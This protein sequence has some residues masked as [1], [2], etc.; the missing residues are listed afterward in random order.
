MGK[1]NSSNFGPF[2]FYRSATSLLFYASTNGTSWDAA[3]GLSLGTVAANVWYHVAAYRVGTTLYLF[4]D[5]VLTYSG[6]MSS[7]L[8][9]NANPIT[10]GGGYNGNEAVSGWI[11][12]VRITNGVGRKSAAFIVPTFQYPDTPSSSFDLY[13]SY[14][15]FGSK[16]DGINSAT[17]LTDVRGNTHSFIGNAQL[18]TA[19]AKFGSASLSF[20]GTGDCV[21]LNN[22]NDFNF[23]QGFTIEFWARVPSWSAYGGF[24]SK[25]INNATYSPFSVYLDVTTGRVG[26]LASVNG[27]SWGVNIF[28]TATLTINQWHHVACVRNGNTFQIFVNGVA[29]T[30]AT[31]AGALMVNTTQVSIGSNAADASV[32]LNGYMD[33]IRITNGA[34]RYTSSF[35]PPTQSFPIPLEYDTYKRSVGLLIHADGVNAS[36][37]VG[38]ITGKVMTAA[39]NAQISTVQ[40]KFGGASLLFDGT[41]DW[42]STPAHADLN[43]TSGDFTI[44]LW[45]YKT[46]AAQAFVLNKDGQSGAYYPQWWV[47]IGASNVLTAALGTGT[48]SPTVTTI[49]SAA[50]INLNQWYHIAFTRSGTTLRLFID[51]A[52]S[53]SATQ[54]VTMTD[55]GR[56][57]YIGYEP[58]TTPLYYTGY[59]DDIRITKGVARYTSTFTPPTRTFSD[60]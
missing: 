4:R 47:S 28:S 49:N 19:Q 57:L 30:S 23:D 27:S 20:D 26:F 21:L 22:S 36:T 45:I 6:T 15:V 31:L 55:G 48:S 54:A 50:P 18:S 53:N 40:S 3:S 52:L 8:I 38:D 1:D 51:G 5:G 37:V 14:V 10:I 13:W 59:L 7:T 58:G 44:E 25:R 11:D 60:V 39:G 16:C 34:A 32:S 41:G 46:V 17:T 29:D 56:P 33:D 43:L 35:T 42:I 9:N 12:E 24:V 2:L